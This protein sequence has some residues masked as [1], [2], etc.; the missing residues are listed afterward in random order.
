MSEEK[1][2]EAAQQMYRALCAALD[3]REWKYA[4]VEEEL[5]VHFGVNG[6]DL[7]LRFVIVV[8]AD[9]Q[10][11]RVLSALPF[12]ISNEKRIEGA[13]ATCAVSCHLADGSF[14]Y[15][16]SDGTIL[17][18]MAASYADS[19]IGEGLFQYLISYTCH[20]VDEYND[21]FMALDKGVLSIGDFLDKNG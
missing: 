15:D 9:R 4:K 16:I 19:Q 14:D 10:L 5:L 18:R 8:D 2:M 20:V 12:K 3:A 13:I 6:D 7:P 11:I 21:Q 1:K 17:F